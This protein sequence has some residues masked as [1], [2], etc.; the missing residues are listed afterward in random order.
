MGRIVICGAGVIGLSA[1]MMLARDGHEVTVLE[2]DSAAAPADPVDAWAGWQ[3]EG[4]AQFRQP[5]NLLPGA[6]QVL[7]AELPELTDALIQAG[8]CWIDLLGVQ[9]PGVTDRAEQPGDDRFRSPSGRRPVLETVFAQVAESTAGVTVRRGVRVQGLVAGASAIDGL[10][11]VVRVRTENGLDLAADLVVDAGGRRSALPDWL[12]E[13]GTPPPVVESQHCGFLYY[14]RNYRGQLP[15]QLGPIAAALGSIS[16]LTLPADNDSWSV[17]IAL[18]SVDTPLKELRH[19]DVFERVVRA[20]PLQAHWVEGEPLTDVLPMAGVLDRYHRFVAEGRP[21]ATGVVAVGDAWASTNPSAG[22]G[23]SVGLLHAQLLR[24]T[25]RAHL[26]DPA[27]LAVAFDAG[28][29]AMVTPHYRNQLRADRARIA[30]MDAIR[31]GDPPPPLDD[32]TRRF[33]VA[34]GRDAVVFRA[35]LETVSC[36]AL[37]EEVMVRPGMAERVAQLGDGEPGRL[38]AP[39]RNRLLELLAG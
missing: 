12:R 32:D 17:T 31:Q 20:H 22:R 30:E 28:T 36:L 39:D 11:H 14:T 21:L 18:A 27:A 3:R 5:H 8:C 9:P 35:M 4:I 2:A 6:R 23:I 37:P 16:M 29:E 25:V 13:L 19:V 26:D 10:P 34:S 1:A 33:L 7:D 24:N 15:Q 38:P